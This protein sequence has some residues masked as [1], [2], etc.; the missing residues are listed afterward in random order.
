MKSDQQWY[1]WE[2]LLKLDIR[3]K[4]ETFG[5]HLIFGQNWKLFLQSDDPLYVSLV[6]GGICLLIDDVFAPLS[7]WVLIGHLMSRSIKTPLG[8]E[9]KK[10]SSWKGGSD[11]EKKSQQICRGRFAQPKNLVENQQWPQVGWR[12]SSS[13]PTHTLTGQHWPIV[14]HIGLAS[15]VPRYHNPT[16]W[17]PSLLVNT[18]Q[19]C[20]TIPHDVPTLWCPSLVNSANTV[21]P[22]TSLVNT[23]PPTHTQMVSPLHRHCYFAV[24]HTHRH[25]SS[26]NCEFC[27]IIVRRRLPIG[28]IWAS[29][30]KDFFTFFQQFCVSCR[31]TV[32]LVCEERILTNLVCVLSTNCLTVWQGKVS[33]L[34]PSPSLII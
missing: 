29:L 26:W 20:P 11:M 21:P 13:L 24:R 10:L 31:C 6:W 28:L 17:C 33:T 2:F 9:A 18:G 14:G 4:I 16:H 27:R 15:T 1:L 8:R 23:V 7:S 5:Q 3:P 30:F 32:F 22:H 19:H 25:G 34:G 12:S